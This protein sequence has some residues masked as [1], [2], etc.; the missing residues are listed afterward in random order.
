MF[1]SLSGLKCDDIY[2]HR[3]LLCYSY[4]NRRVDLLTISSYHNISSVR[5]PRLPNLFPDLSVPRPYKFENK[6]VSG[7]NVYKTFFL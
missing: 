2:Y 3:E 4:E 6:K 7:N 5:E 1:F